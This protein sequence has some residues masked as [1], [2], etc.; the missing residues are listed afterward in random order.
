MR[1]ITLEEHFTSP[2][3]VA[4]N[5]RFNLPLQSQPGELTDFYK[6]HTAFGVELLDADANL[7][8]GQKELIAHGNAARILHL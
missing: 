4:E 2:E 6:S 7:I 1:V 5:S 8:Q 3:I